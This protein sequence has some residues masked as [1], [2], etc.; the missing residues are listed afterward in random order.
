MPSGSKSNLPV[1]VFA[2]GGANTD[3]SASYPLYDLCHLATDSIAVAIQYRLGP[4]GFLALESAGIEGNMGIKDQ[5]A[6]LEWVQTNI[7]AFGG[8][9]KK[10]LLFGQSSGADDVFAIASLTQA[11]SLVSSVIC[12]SGGGFDLH[13]NETMQ[14][15]GADYAIGLNCSSTDVSY[16]AHKTYMNCYLHCRRSSV[17]NLDLS[18]NLSR[19]MIHFQCSIQG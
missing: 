1:K 14:N 5:L 19:C 2:H 10:V 6:A 12:E 13:V 9:S 18:I 3:G 16:S 17:S 4:L 8:D 11:K 15:V 7:A